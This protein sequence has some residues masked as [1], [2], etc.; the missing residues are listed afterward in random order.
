MKRVA[1]EIIE[2]AL[3]QALAAAQEEASANE[4]VCAGQLLWR[5]LVDLMEEKRQRLFFKITLIHLMTLK[6][7]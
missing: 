5:L 3:Q 1:A 4:A 2:P 7:R 6:D